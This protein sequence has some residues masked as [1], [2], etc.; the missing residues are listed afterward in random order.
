MD[1]KVEKIGKYTVMD[2]LGEG[3][4]SRVYKAGTK[5][6]GGF[7]KFF[8][9]KVLNTDKAGDPGMVSMFMDEARIGAQLVHPNIVP[10]LDF[11]QEGNSYYIAME[12]VAGMSLGRVMERYFRRKAVFS[13]DEVLYVAREV[14]KAL[15]YAH[16]FR[17]ADRKKQV[18]IHRDVS[19]ENVLINGNGLIKLCD[20]GI[21]QGS[22]RSDKTKTGIIKGKISYIAPDV[23]KGGRAGPGSDIYSLGV[24]MFEMLKGERMG[25][26]RLRREAVEG[27]ECDEAMKSLILQA[28]DQST[29]SRFKSAAAML[30]GVSRFS[31]D[32]LSAGRSLARGVIRRR[33]SSTKKH[34]KDKQ[35]G[36]LKSAAGKSP[37]KKSGA[38]KEKNIHKTFYDQAF[39]IKLVMLLLFLLFAA[40]LLLALFGVVLTK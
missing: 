22:F 37:D 26:Q 1:K 4:M 7:E 23:L 25:S 28:V 13:V 2:T 14:L 8:A 18:V 40:S 31:F 27:M 9:I 34:G 38:A 12:Y 36:P 15:D 30:A 20:F 5:G 29:D 21:A 33:R 3:G 16:N 32:P 11:G 17:D 24:V 6:P 35:A 19:P 39:T 10:I